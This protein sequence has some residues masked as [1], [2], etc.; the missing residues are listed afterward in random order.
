MALKKQLIVA[1][2]LTAL[3]VPALSTSFVVLSTAP[4]FAKG[5]NNGN[6]NG[7]GNGNGG[8]HGNG[9][10]RSELKGANASHANESALEHASANS[11]VGMAATYR[12]AA[13]VTIEAEAAA[14][15][16]Q[17]ALDAYEQAHAGLTPEELQAGI[18]AL[19]PESETYDEDLAALQEALE[20]ASQPDEELIAL[21]DAADQATEELQAAV[22]AE[23]DALLN[24]T[25]GR[26]ISE[27]AVA[28]LRSNLGL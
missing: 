7:H 27:D 12:D 17:A 26:E 28:E 2:A 14:T 18:D 6:G 9:A 8:N 22:D 25:D 16:A 5:P 23:G 10:V 13:Q 20:A 19:D 3:A 1:A 21:Q 15:D 4:A 24:L 11:R